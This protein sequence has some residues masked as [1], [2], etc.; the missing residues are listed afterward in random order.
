MQAFIWKST[1]NVSDN[2][3]DDGGLI[4]VAESLEAARALIVASSHGEQYR[5]EVPPEC[6]ALTEA[7]DI[8]L[9]LVSG[10]PRLVV[11]PNA[12]CC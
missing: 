10:E 11:F 7:P 4:V 8:T 2:Y 5:R 9:H 12:G 1:S 6:G 3:H